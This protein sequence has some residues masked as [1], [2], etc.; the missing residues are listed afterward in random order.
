LASTVAY[1][2]LFIFLML[3][4]KFNVKKIK[5]NNSSI[6]LF[7]GRYRAAGWEPF[8]LAAPIKNLKGVCDTRTLFV[9]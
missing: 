8:A 9:L 6:A 2:R 3:N 1:Y 5:K 7:N 4:E